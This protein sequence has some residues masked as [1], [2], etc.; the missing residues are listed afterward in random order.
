MKEVQQA[1]DHF[2]N[3]LPRKTMSNFG[4]NAD[5]DLAVGLADHKHVKL[6]NGTCRIFTAEGRNLG[7]YY[8]TTNWRE[9]G[10][11]IERERIEL[12]PQIAKLEGSDADWC[13]VYCGECAYGPTVL[14][15]AM[16]AFVA[17]RK[18]VRDSM[19]EGI[20]RQIEDGSSATPYN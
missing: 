3:Q 19:A 1:V 13:A 20:R 10:P 7:D 14:I 12:I 11:L 5:L 17:G 4:Q 9:G 8:P 15:A 16:R 2:L 18:R 6:V